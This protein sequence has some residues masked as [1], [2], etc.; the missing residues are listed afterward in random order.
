MRTPDPGTAT[1]A[2]QGGT[3]L[4][5]FLA[6]TVAII[7]A[8]GFLYRALSEDLLRD[9]HEELAAVAELKARQVENWLAAERKYM[10]GRAT[11]LFF[12][13]AVRAWLDCRDPQIK[14]KL[15]DRLT[16]E[17]SDPAYAGVELLDM[18]GKRLLAVGQ[19]EHDAEMLRPHIAKE[20]EDHAP[21]L[22]DLHR[23]Q[24]GDAHLGF[25][26]AVRN[27]AT[28]ERPP[29]AVL[30]YSINTEPG[31]LPLIAAWPRPSAS[32]E[33]VLVRQDGDQL[34]HLTGM[35][36]GEGEP[37]SL[38]IP[39]D[40]RLR[41]AVQ[42]V[43][44]GT[45]IYAGPDYRGVET[46]LAAHPVAG[47]SWMLL[48]KIDEA[49]VTAGLRQLG[50]SS[51][52]L[53]L[54]AIGTAGALIFMFWR[55][56]HLRTA[57]I[58]AEQ[59]QTIGL[60]EQRFG[61][62]LNSIGDAVIATD[63]AGNVEFLNPIAAQLTGWTLDEARGR[64]LEEVFVIVNEETHQPLES[65]VRLV[66]REGKIVG[67]ANHTLLIARDGSELPIA[68]SGAPIRAA[69][70]TNEVTGVVLVFRDQSAARAAE[71]NLRKLSLAIEQSPESIVISD[72]DGNIE[73][74]NTAFEQVSG[75]AAEELLG[76]NPRILKSGK[77]P[78]ATYVAMWDAL[79][80]G[81]SWQGEFIN[82]KKDGSEYVEY[83]IIT[84]LRQPDGTITH[85]VAVKEDIA[86]KKRNAVELDLHRHHLEELV[87]QRTT[88][89]SIAKTQAE[90][91]NR[92]KSAFLANMSH[93]IRTPM[94][95]ILGL[96]HLLRRAGASPE[97]TDRLGKIDSAGRH[98]L[99]IINDILDLSKI[100]AG[101]LQLE[102][103]DFALGT[104]LDHVRSMIADSTQAKGLI[105]DIDDD[106]VPLWLRGD[107]TR[108]RQAL[109]NYAGNAVKFTKQGHISLRA[110]LQEEQGDALLV[111]FEVQDTG[112]GI[113]AADLA[114]LFDP[115]EQVD[116][117]TTRQY[118]GTGLGLPITRRLAQIMG[119]DAGVD[120]TPGVG[121]TFWFTACLR[122]GH[123][124]MPAV[125]AEETA[126]RNAETLL[127]QYYA[128]TRLL[129]AEDNPINREVALEL[130]HGV[131]LAVDAAEDGRAALALAQHQPYALVLMD[132]QMPH[133]DGLD[134]T[135]AIRA[136]PHWQDTPILAMTANAFEE[137]RRAC[138]AAG[139]NDFVAKPV[140]PEMLYAAL[141]KWLSQP[142]A[143]PAA[144]DLRGGPSD[145]V[146]PTPTFADTELQYLSAIPGIN[147]AR[148][149]A[150]VRG[151]ATKFVRLLTLFANSHDQDAA[152][153]SSGLAADDLEGTKRL[154]HNL[155]GSAGN[156]GA[157]AVQE[158]ATA[159]H[160]AIAHESGRAEIDQHCAALGTALAQLIN[161]IRLLPQNLPSTAAVDPEQLA[162]VLDRL[163]A[164]LA[165]GDM[166]ADDLARDAE[167]LL[168][169][170][171]GTATAAA[172]RARIDACDYEAALAVLRASR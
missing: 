3:L 129:L 108:L 1:R 111:R 95:A 20:L 23:H 110:K 28:P 54:L 99:A 124:I 101:K 15:H 36:N 86:E 130:L 102:E 94:N 51:L 17:L 68:D 166:A 147:L 21:L 151:D 154:A 63:A 37:M 148:G 84:P 18:Q 121:S 7:A 48:A 133:M 118:G 85:Y 116:T 168:R 114:R 92:A 171:L 128:G 46:L 152:N 89:L 27:P 8:G 16:S 4:A 162:T 50:A 35:H 138:E 157:T 42:A 83:A 169:A 170:G 112:I 62:T 107:P 160:A 61:V 44:H 156:L 109:L 59:A 103:S 135:R 132:V 150:M 125:P 29:Q 90:T 115:F 145:A 139:M 165:I 60:L 106:H 53:M 22:L 123:G 79:T 126:T 25:L 43:L 55:Q 71:L 127:R 34:M 87:L 41:P 163:A 47:T 80:H 144:P 38:G 136:L 72:L 119:G 96:T 88:E 76:Q 49:E 93:E 64:P 13:E 24:D 56:Q 113:A 137:D 67:L 69:G 14:E 40:Q 74:I 140:E 149:L 167:P 117:S 52:A 155:K 26:A 9:R 134:A 98:L 6:F 70:E 164:F 78:A 159:L 122:R 10:R 19:V 161:A 105:I 142:G 31:L 141:Y 97:Q 131:G 143:A 33:I 39:M 172:L 104:V 45:G 5:I 66:L 146:P 120:S 81:Q 91:A 153:L 30:L 58:Q 65:P 12:A 32:G 158:A 82:R 77:T 57:L 11:G 75:Y 2:V 100:E 73:Y